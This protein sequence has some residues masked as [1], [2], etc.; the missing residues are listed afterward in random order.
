[1][2]IA[3]LHVDRS[4]RVLASLQDFLLNLVPSFPAR[5]TLVLI[6]LP[7]P[8]PGSATQQSHRHPRRS[9]RQGLGRRESLFSE[10][11]TEGTE[12]PVMQLKLCLSLGRCILLDVHACLFLVFLFES[13]TS[14]TW[15]WQSQRQG[16]HS[17]KWHGTGVPASAGICRGYV[18]SH[19]KQ[20]GKSCP[21]TGASIDSAFQEQKCHQGRG[22]Y[23]D[24]ESRERL[25]P[26]P[27]KP[28][29]ILLSRT[30]ILTIFSLVSFHWFFLRNYYSFSD[31]TIQTVLDHNS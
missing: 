29:L 16:P 23:K 7:V 12:G 22:Y 3:R 5:L 19:D 9:R 15:L 24:I 4:Y 21:T 18:W 13:R 28:G 14:Q 17:H 11:E 2:V 20:F 6:A 8:L 25:F 31:W 30:I 26:S 1:M 10:R 27:Q